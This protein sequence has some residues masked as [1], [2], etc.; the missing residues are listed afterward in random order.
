MKILIT[1]AKGQVGT[2]IVIEAEK[3]GHEVY[4]FASS[5]LDIT[6]K[7]IVDGQLTKIKPDVVIN[8]AA[9]TAVD[10]AEAEQEKAYAVNEAGVKNLAEICK[11]LD[12][13]LFHISTDY[14][15]DGEKKEPYV[16]TDTPNPTS[17]YGASKLAGEVALQQIW[18]KHIILRVSWVFG[19]HG[20]NFVKTMLRLS[21]SRDELSVV[22]DQYGAPTA[23]KSIA[24][25]LLNIIEK[26][27]FG[28][29]GFPW[30]VYHYQSD[31]CVTWYGFAEEIFSQ[32]SEKKWRG[33]RV[34]LKAISSG[35]FPTPVKRPG[36]S[37]LDGEKIQRVLGVQAADWKSQLSV[38]LDNIYC[39][40]SHDFRYLKSN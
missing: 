6:N 29:T 13:P 27:K 20:N 9:Y 35:Q 21:E 17:V 23:A 36:N 12:I 40:H 8:A 18:N 1:G 24:G 19:E 32:A 37:K 4:G 16:E 2:D 3:R 25:C 26:S 28:V 7:D 14:V 34:K 11:T 33:R 39:F 5:E 15:F 31:P 38:M 22:N 30:G 10:K